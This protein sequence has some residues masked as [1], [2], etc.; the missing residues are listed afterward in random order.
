M[1]RSYIQGKYSFI[2][3]HVVRISWILLFFLDELNCY[4]YI[5]WDYI[6]DSIPETY[7]SHWKFHLI[8]SRYQT[9]INE[10]FSQRRFR[11]IHLSYKGL[12][13]VHSEQTLFLGRISCCRRLEECFLLPYISDL[14]GHKSVTLVINSGVSSA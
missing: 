13:P 11:W 10:S 2:R 14:G 5:S 8:P 9:I 7:I 12:S 3:C 6:F 1:L 4:E